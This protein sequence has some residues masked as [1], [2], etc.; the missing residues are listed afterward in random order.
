MST[1]VHSAQGEEVEGIHKSGF[2]FP[3]QLTLIA[4][5]LGLG[6]E[7]L[8]FG[9][10]FGISVPIWAAL[11]VIALLVSARLEAVDASRSS[12]LLVIPILFFA[13]MTF[14]RLEPMTAFLSFVSI[15]VLLTLWTW[16]FQADRLQDY[17][18]LD[19]FVVLVR[20][21]LE[22]WIRPW[23]V[24]GDTQ[25]KVVKEGKGRSA[26]LAILRG[27][28]LAL[29]VL[30]ILLALLVSADLVFAD[31]VEEAL[32]WLNLERLLD[33]TARAL[34]VLVCWVFFLG[35]I[36]IALHDPGER[37]LIGK[38]EPIVKPFLGV[39]ESLVVL[40][41]VDLLFMIFVA[42]QFAYLFGGESNITA[43]G[44]TYSEYARR[45]FGELVAV[46]V[47]SLGL[48]LA[49]GNF[50]KREDRRART[51]YN[52][53][54]ALLVA[55]VGVILIS[56]LRRLLLY[57]EAYG[58]TRLRTY[59][60]FFIPWMGIL[61]L[62]FLILLLRGNLRRFAP[63]VALGAFGYV[64]TLGLLNIDAFIVDRNVERLE[65]TGEIDL[66][67]LVS[68]SEDAVPGLV[69]LAEDGP[70]DVREE[71]IPQLACW[72]AQL[73]ERK[74]DLSWQSFHL[75][76]YT[77]VEDLESLK[78]LFKQYEITNERGQW[79]VMVDGKE[80]YCMHQWWID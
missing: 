6:V 9:H 37:K 72:Y 47:L 75:S 70:K 7:I 53:L 25:R 29:P 34:V 79:Y 30:I 55:E 76:R 17:G 64:A 11:C 69:D 27:L 67:Y 4:L 43:A 65:D 35:A 2:R 57:E 26:A 80:V 66:D 8:Y 33:W 44:Y 5:L 68:L 10:P 19:F 24:M 36:V 52:V 22:A 32:S 1:E 21:P 54:S 73:D 51:W 40:G 50:T 28:I 48:I 38:D 63:V 31:W 39:I 20:V 13:I 58:F 41:L 16:S 62:A 15:L 61:L 59:T 14:L 74:D 71:L 78:S 60:H 45:G 46:G 42:V 12:F 77:A 49:F 18:W 56:A 23:S 3:Q